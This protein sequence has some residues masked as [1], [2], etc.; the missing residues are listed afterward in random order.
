M[1]PALQND[2]ELSLKKRARRRLVG[3]VALVLLMVIVLPMVLEDRAHLTPQEA[4]KVSMPESKDVMVEMNASQPI[5]DAPDEKPDT[6]APVSVQNEPQ[7]VALAQVQV[8]SEPQ[9][10][11]ESEPKIVEAQKIESTVEKKVE[12]QEKVVKVEE[13]K[14]IEPK[15]AEVSREVKVEKKQPEK[16]KTNFAIQIGVY[17]DMANVER[18][19]AK[20]KEAGFAFHKERI[21][22]ATGVKVRLRAGGYQSRQEAADALTKLKASGVPGMVISL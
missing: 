2:Q 12:V 7:S 6:P 19:E 21:A 16:S 1:P 17:S 20:L 9:V 8:K 22:T 15:V 11:S 4:I 13:L 3:A 10:K 18:L 14:P 5:I